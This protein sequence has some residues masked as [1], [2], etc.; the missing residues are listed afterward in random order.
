LPFNYTTILVS[1]IHSQERNRFID[2]SMSD[3]A[4]TVDT[5]E[6]KKDRCTSDCSWIRCTDVVLRVLER[7]CCYSRATV[8]IADV[9]SCLA[10]ETEK[11][12]NESSF[13]GNKKTE[14]EPVCSSLTPLSVVECSTYMMSC[15]VTRGPC[16]SSQS[17]DSV[18]FGTLFYSWINTEMIFFAHKC[19]TQP[20]L[21]KRGEKTALQISTYFTIWW[22]QRCPQLI[23]RIIQKQSHWQV[24]LHLHMCAI[25]LH[26]FFR[27]F[28]CLE[29]V[30][31]ISV[32]MNCKWCWGALM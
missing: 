9:F 6:K 19:Y 29:T 7:W 31:T 22:W 13:V 24:P 10:K 4:N 11:Y 16:S 25:I 23:I 8:G 18:Q 5:C 14:V 12:V 32:R 2:R 17:F 3:A 1:A 28:C 21:G 30:S 27:L 15:L 20:H 26:G